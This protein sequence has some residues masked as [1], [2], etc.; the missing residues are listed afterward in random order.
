[1]RLQGR[2]TDFSVVLVDVRVE[3]HFSLEGLEVHLGWD[4]GVMIGKHYLYF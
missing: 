2:M 3:E 4:S 1:M